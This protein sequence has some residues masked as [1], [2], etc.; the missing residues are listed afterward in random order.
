MVVSFTGKGRGKIGPRWRQKSLA[1]FG[2]VNFGTSLR[3]VQE[4]IKYI[5]G[6][7]SLKIR[8]IVW[9]E[10]VHIFGIVRI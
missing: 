10:E 9:A 3:Q 2:L 1:S 7:I 6:Y 4:R 5:I 8:R